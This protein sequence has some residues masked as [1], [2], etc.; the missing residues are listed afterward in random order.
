MSTLLNDS[1]CFRQRMSTRFNESNRQIFRLRRAYVA[2]ISLINETS[3]LN[4]KHITQVVCKRYPDFSN[5]LH[6]CVSRT[7][8][9]GDKVTRW[10]GDV[11]TRWHGDTVTW[12]QGAKV[13]RWHGDKVT[14]QADKV[15]WRYFDMVTLWQGDK[16][17]WCTIS[18]CHHVTS[19]H[20]PCRLVALSPCL[21]VTMST[22]DLVTLSPYHYVTLSP[23]PLDTLSPH[24]NVTLSPVDMVTRWHSFW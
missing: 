17:T 13:P 14:R 20:V 18:S 2:T 10:Q 1:K 4:A 5:E 12:W 24:H 8:Y 7:L 3:L 11:M 6:Q 21:Y 19:S 22:C 9:Q 16:V 15:P 23:C